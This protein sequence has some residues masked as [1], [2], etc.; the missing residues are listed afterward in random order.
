MKEVN[1]HIER[2]HWL[3]NPREEVTEETKV[4]PSVW[5]MR[6]KLHDNTGK[7]YKHKAR[8]NFHRSENEYVVNYFNMYAPIVPWMTIWMVLVLAII[9]RWSTQQVD[10]VLVY[11]QAPIKYNMYMEL[12]AVIHTKYGDNNTHVLH[13]LNNLY[14][15]K[16]G[17]KVWND[18]LV[19]GLQQIGFFHSKIDKCLFYI[20][21]VILIVYVDDGIFASPFKAAID[22]TIAFL[23][24]VKYDIED[25]GTLAYYLGVNVETLADGQIKLS[26]QLLVDQFL[27]DVKLP[28]R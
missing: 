3:L 6:R 25:Q 22:L 14:G 11:P 8:I 18:H 4:L 9:N 19:S 2:K 27:N 5:E 7:V 24:A 1:D 21:S 26:Q 28:A 16:Q 23:R 20:G 13:I 10:F 15:Q 17:G 12:P